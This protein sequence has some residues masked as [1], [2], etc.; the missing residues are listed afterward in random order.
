M[1]YSS[2]FVNNLAAGEISVEVTDA[3]GCIS[4]TADTIFEPVQLTTDISST[5]VTCWSW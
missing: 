2:Q 4:T 1:G 5:N 3:N